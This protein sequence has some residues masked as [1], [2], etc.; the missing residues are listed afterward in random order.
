[1]MSTELDGQLTHVFSK[2]LAIV[3]SRHS[4]HMAFDNATP[5]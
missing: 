3:F 5:K 4:I 2:T 1:L